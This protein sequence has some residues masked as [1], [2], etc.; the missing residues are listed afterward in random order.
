MSVLTAA[1][2]TCL[3]SQQLGRLAK[4]GANG[5]PHVVPVG[6]RFNEDDET[7]DIDGFGI[8]DNT[9]NINTRTIP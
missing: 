1:E 7:I 8:D 9:V 4:T 3:K 5:R 2:M 6:F